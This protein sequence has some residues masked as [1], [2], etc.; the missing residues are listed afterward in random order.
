MA[1]GVPLQPVVLSFDRGSILVRGEVR[2]PYTVWDDR[3]RAFRA[4][5]LYYQEIVEYLR[6]SKM[7]FSDTVQNLVPSPN[8]R[9]GIHLRD[10]QEDAL[11]AWDKGGRKG[12]IVLPTG[13]GKTVIGI[14]AIELVDQPS[15]VVV[16]T[17][18]SGGAV[19]KQA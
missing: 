18:R 15:I 17:L 11:E 16:P 8:L 9:S 6:N 1:C 3:V 4:Q 2:I 10:Y 5:A 7:T 14:K 13:A 19:E 12:I